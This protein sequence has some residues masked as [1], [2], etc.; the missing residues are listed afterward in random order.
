MPLFSA[1]LIPAYI[2]AGFILVSTIGSPIILSQAV[3]HQSE[4]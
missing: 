1:S 2:F 3:K 4:S